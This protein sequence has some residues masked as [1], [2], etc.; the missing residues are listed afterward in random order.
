MKTILLLLSLLFPMK[1]FCP[2]FKDNGARHFRQGVIQIGEIIQP[3]YILQSIIMIESSGR[4]KVINKKE[5][6]FGILQIRKSMIREA[7]DLSGY[8]KYRLK[9]ALSRQK[10]IEIWYLVQSHRNPDYDLKTACKVWNGCG[11]E[12]KMIIYFTKVE[13]QL[14]KLL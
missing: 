5:Q 13:K 8:R 12:Q 10:S 3:D 4:E 11:K 9:D 7:N 1:T 2:E 14:K 6:A